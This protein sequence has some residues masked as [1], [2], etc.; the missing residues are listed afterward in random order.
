MVIAKDETQADAYSCD[1]CTCDIFVSFFECRACPG[2]ASSEENGAVSDGDI[3]LC[4]GCVAEGR[5]CACTRP[6]SPIQR[7][8]YSSVR[9]GY[10][11][12]A[13]AL[14]EMTGSEEWRELGPSYVF[15][16]PS[17]QLLC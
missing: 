7:F 17:C 3:H 8:P 10:N 15:L 13:R 16:E 1:Y 11:K 14:R 2:R 12:A 9:N 5:S 4:P 6:M